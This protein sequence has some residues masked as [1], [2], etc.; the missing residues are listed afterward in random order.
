MISALI[1]LSIAGFAWAENLPDLGFYYASEN[2]SA[3]YK[4]GEL[5]VRF[6]D[7]DAASKLAEG[8]LLMGPLTT[9]AVKG[10]ISDYILTGSSIEKEYGE[11]SKWCRI[12]RG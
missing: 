1:L 5:I 12:L 4:P 8:P 2:D 11:E 9:K 10:A 6:A 7:V 3:A